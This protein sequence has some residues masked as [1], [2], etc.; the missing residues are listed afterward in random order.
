MSSQR[1]SVTFA[2]ALATAFLPELATAAHKADWSGYSDRFGRGLRATGMLVIHSAA[3]VTVLSVPIWTAYRF[4]AF[5][6]AAV[7]PTAQ[8]LSVWALGLFSFAGY[9]FVLRS[10]Y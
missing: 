10:F 5:S 1:P 6:A 2:V 4:G 8:V 9:M 7:V 3:L